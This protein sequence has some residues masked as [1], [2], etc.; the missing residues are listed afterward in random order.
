VIALGGGVVGDVAGFVSATYMRGIPCIQI[1]TTVLAQA[2]SSIGGKTGVDYPQGKNLIGAF[3]QPIAVYID[4]FTLSTLDDRN[5][6]SGLIEVLKHGLIRDGAFF[7]YF[8]RSIDKIMD[9]SHGEYNQTMTELMARNSRIKNRIVASDPKEKNLRKILNYGHTI[10][11]AIE[12]LSGYT[13]LHGESV[14][15][16]IACEAYFSHALGFCSKAEYRR[17]LRIIEALGLPVRI[18]ANIDTGAIIDAM[19]IDKKVVGGRVQFVLLRKIGEIQR[20]EK[21]SCVHTIDEASLRRLIDDF[22][23]TDRK[24]EMN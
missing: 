9:R 15:I 10:G 19:R 12:H 4:P 23:M 7:D 16:G 13:L 6:K 18:P 21:G 11:H 24:G 5:Y 2:D 17:Q 14:A 22:R 3:H 20:A 8:V 1:P